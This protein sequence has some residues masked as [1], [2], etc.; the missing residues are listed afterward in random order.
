MV[1]KKLFR[2]LCKSKKNIALNCLHALVPTK[3]TKVSS[4]FFFS[5]DVGLVKHV[6]TTALNI[7]NFRVKLLH[8]YTFYHTDDGVM[9]MMVIF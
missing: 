8:L 1:N 7:R 4:S 9:M 3:M 6:S 5:C 2:R